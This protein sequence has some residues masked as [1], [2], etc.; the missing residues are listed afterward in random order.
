MGPLSNNLN[1]PSLITNNH[2]IGIDYLKNSKVIKFVYDNKLYQL[3]L[4]GRKIYTNEEFDITIIE[5]KKKDNINIKNF[6][7]IDEEILNIKTFQ[8]NYTNSTAYTFE[9]KDGN[10]FFSLEEIQNISE[11]G[12]LFRK[13]IKDKKK[14]SFVCSGTPIL[15]LSSFKV[16]GLHCV[17]DQSEKVSL[18]YIISRPIKDYLSL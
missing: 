10:F 5:I 15:S 3:L 2:L 12:N 7:E 14:A 18:G 9:Y 8:K 4:E 11:E 13:T 16:I 1:F 17:Y 6:L